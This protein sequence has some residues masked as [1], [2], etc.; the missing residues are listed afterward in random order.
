MTAIAKLGLAI[1]P[2][3]ASSSASTSTA[4]AMVTAAVIGQGFSQGW[5]S[6]SRM[7]HAREYRVTPYFALE[8]PSGTKLET[9]YKPDGSILG[10]RYVKVCRRATRLQLTLVLL[11][12]TFDL[13]MQTYPVPPRN[14][15]VIYAPK[16]LMFSLAKR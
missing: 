8:R 6:E 12:I 10:L 3:L 5:T 16:L 14:L 2:Q 11:H 1:I 13:G 7:V 9:T 15:G 4:V